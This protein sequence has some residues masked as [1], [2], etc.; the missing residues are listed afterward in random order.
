MSK[1]STYDSV[2]N[3]PAVIY[4]ISTTPYLLNYYDKPNVITGNALSLIANDN[5]SNTAINLST[6]NKTAFSIAGG[7]FPND[8]SRAMGVLGLKTT[9]S[10]FIMAQTI[11]SGNSAVKYKTT[12]G[13]NTYSPKTESYSV[14]INGATRIANGE[15]N[16]VLR[17]PTTIQ[18][19]NNCKQSSPYTGI[20]VSDSSNVF[21]TSNGGQMW[22]RL[23]N[24][25]S[26]T[27]TYEWSSFVFD[28]NHYFVYTTNSNI[29][30]FTSDGID[31]IKIGQ[32]NSQNGGNIDNPDNIYG[33]QSHTVRPH[34][35]TLFSFN[36]TLGH[37]VIVIGVTEHYYDNNEDNDV[38]SKISDPPPVGFNNKKIYLFV[39]E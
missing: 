31:W 27:Y 24:I 7:S 39:D 12:T 20:A 37:K 30:F 1:R 14:D 35:N 8:T 11:V 33:G 36:N 26:P 34:F 17:T 4:D 16:T 9:D 2:F 18:K 5:S 23:P 3:E 38:T 29:L 10:S 13:F 25:N 6:P 22:N 19:M 15:V 21:I 28:S 32:Q